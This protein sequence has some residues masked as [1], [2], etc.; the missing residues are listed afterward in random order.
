[1]HKSFV[2]CSKGRLASRTGETGVPSHLVRENPFCKAQS[3][4]EVACW[5]WE[6]LG[7]N[8]L[9]LGVAGQRKGRKTGRKG[10]SDR[11]GNTQEPVY[12]FICT[13]CVARF[14]HGSFTRLCG[15]EMLT[16]PSMKGNKPNKASTTELR[17]PSSPW[18]A[19][20]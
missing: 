3:G 4:N 7:S 11:I 15:L 12:S 19:G 5:L 17:P 13:P 6:K 9:R 14:Q 18:D 2:G 8:C 20:F 1:M 10:E 16:T